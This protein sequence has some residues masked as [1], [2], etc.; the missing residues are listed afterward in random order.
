MNNDPKSIRIFDTSKLVIAVIL[1]MVMVLLIFLPDPNPKNTQIS[2]T[3]P[4]TEKGVVSDQA[5]ISTLLPSVPT[6]TPTQTVTATQTQTLTQ[7][8][9]P[10]KTVTP[11]LTATA[12]H[13]STPS[14]TTTSP[15]TDTPNAPVEEDL[16]DLALAT[17]LAVGQSARVRT[18]LNL[19]SAPGLT[20]QVTTVH[21]TGV[22][23]EIIGGPICT[24]FENGAY[25]WWQVQRPDGAVGWS[26]EGSATNLFYFLEP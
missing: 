10:T 26:A 1:V 24:P 11:T 12:T 4:L 13:T 3:Q 5:S 6:A 17:R 20:N 2:P 19:R 22:R 15:I 16:C 21:I 23:L 18:N 8:S 25:R 14:Q 9:T 7:T